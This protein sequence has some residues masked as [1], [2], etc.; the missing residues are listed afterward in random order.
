MFYLLA[1]TDGRTRFLGK[2]YLRLLP[3]KGHI[4]FVIINILLK[5]IRIVNETNLLR[6]EEIYFTNW[7]TNDQRHPHQNIYISN[8][9]LTVI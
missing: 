9:T 7:M 1:Q 3:K 4:L 5:E 8:K 2:F 6:H